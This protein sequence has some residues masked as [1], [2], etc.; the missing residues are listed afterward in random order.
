MPVGRV[1]HRRR[2]RLEE[3]RRVP[4]QARAEVE[5]GELLVERADRL[6]L[7]DVEDA[8]EARVLVRVQVDE[9]AARRQD[10][11]LERLEVLRHVLGHEIDQIGGGAA[12]GPAGGCGHGSW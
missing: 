12:L 1:L 7:D 11:G 10:R 2:H 5:G 9:I 3:S 6:L 8:L 4:A